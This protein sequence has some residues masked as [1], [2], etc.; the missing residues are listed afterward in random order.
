MVNRAGNATIVDPY[1]QSPFGLV[2]GMRLT[3]QKLGAPTCY[4]GSVAL[5]ILSTDAST[6]FYRGINFG[7]DALT[8]AGVAISMATG[9]QIVWFSSAGQAGSL[10]RSDAVTAGNS[11]RL[12]LGEGNAALQNNAGVNNLLVASSGA[13][14]VDIWVDGSLRNIQIFSS[15]GHDYLVA[16]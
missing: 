6:K 4:N 16:A 13:N 11:M 5:S 12:I 14:P 1:N 7:S 15:G 2:E 10:I 8:S 9:H 3:M